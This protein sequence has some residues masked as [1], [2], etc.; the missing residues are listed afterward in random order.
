MPEQFDRTNVPDLT[1]I[2]GHWD[3]RLIYSHGDGPA[4]V[5]RLVAVLPG[6]SWPS[7]PEEC[8]AGHFDTEWILDGRVLLCLGCGIDAT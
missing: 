4:A 6:R 1:E 5:G 8:T 3:P 2:G 7:T